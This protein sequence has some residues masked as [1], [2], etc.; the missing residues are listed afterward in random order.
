MLFVLET[1]RECTSPQQQHIQ[2]DPCVSRYLAEVSQHDI[3][4][5]ATEHELFW[6]YK[7]HN[8]L[9]ARDKIIGSALRFVIKLARQYSRNPDVTKDLIAAGNLGLVRALDRFDP[10]R[11]TRF[12]SYAT[13]WV[14]LEMR[15][16][17]YG[18]SLVSVPL[19][20]Q[21]AAGRIKREAARVEAA[22]GRTA[23]A[24]QLSTKVDLSEKQVR[25]IQESA[26]IRVAAISDVENTLHV[27]A[28]RTEQEAMEQ[29]RNMLLR[30]QIRQLPLVAQQF[31]LLAY[32]GIGVDA[33]S[34]RQ[35]ANVLGTSSE[36]IRQIRNQAL[37][38]LR[39]RFKN[40]LNV[41][42]VSALAG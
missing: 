16:E 35:I 38:L 10:D 15:N 25:R 8:D 14:M 7:R 1:L 19:W 34:L 41:S 27:S 3:L 4:D 17:M 26:D 12:L 37:R 6:R 32:Y 36:R 5:A 13:S 24:A 39:K 21:K 11:G 22:C 18:S 2:D 9:A 29:E 42:S 23:S 31:T 30:H 28:D 33:R 20:R 40:S